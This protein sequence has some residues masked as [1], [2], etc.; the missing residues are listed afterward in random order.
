[1]QLLS[2]LSLIK[3]LL[4]SGDLMLLGYSLCSY[5]VPWLS[6]TISQ[7]GFHCIDILYT[8]GWKICHIAF[9]CDE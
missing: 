9:V 8:F 4:I 7:D 2:V 5:I 1:M 6:L 3:T